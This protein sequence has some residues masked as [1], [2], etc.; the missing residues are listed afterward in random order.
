MIASLRIGWR[1]RRARR[2]YRHRVVPPHARARGGKQ[3]YVN[4][5]GLV[6]ARANRPNAPPPLLRLALLDSRT[7]HQVHNPRQVSREQMR[8][9]L[10]HSPSGGSAVPR[11]FSFATTP[12]SDSALHNAQ[13]GAQRV[14]RLL[15]RPLGDVV[16][17]PHRVACS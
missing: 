3:G 6:P 12:G 2:L 8:M 1:N 11:S 16:P 7:R 9:R 17:V 10:P 15:R 5:A 14:H 4:T 13:R